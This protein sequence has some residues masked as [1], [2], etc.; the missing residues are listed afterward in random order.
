MT[1]SKYHNT[2]TETLVA[3]LATLTDKT[4]ETIKNAADILQELHAR[5]LTHPLMREGVLRYYAEIADGR[6]SA[7]A[8]LAFAG[9]HSILKR[10]VGMPL[11]KQ[12]AFAAGDDTVI[13]IHNGQGEIVSTKKP[14]IQLNAAQLDIAL[15]D[16]KPR[17]FQEQKKMLAAR[18]PRA[19][20]RRSRSALA[21]RADLATGEIVCGQLRFK[22][23]QL[24]G[25]LKTLGFEIVRSS[26]KATAA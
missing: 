1:E 25:A 10:L 9:V 7:T 14:L 5:R 4:A 13:A 8:A 11:A 22:P 20:A 21:I 24:A 16:G 15:A 12:N 6:L 3:D 26:A 17:P 18:Q 19:R 23:H 2:K